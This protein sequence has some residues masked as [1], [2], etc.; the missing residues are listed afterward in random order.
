MAKYLLVAYQT[1]QSPQLLAAAQE[2]ARDDAS[3]EFVLLVPATPT[4]N[5]LVNEEGESSEVARRRG[6]SAREW[7]QET[8]LRMTDARVGDPDPVNA[9][10]DELQRD[11][12]YAAVVISTLPAGISH[13]LRLDVVSQV[14]RRFPNVRVDHVVS[15]VPLVSS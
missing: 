12:S 1:A 7:L 10:A 15:E 5:L 11:E 4:G 2:L 8:G 13:W 3:A 14:R 6:E 9:I